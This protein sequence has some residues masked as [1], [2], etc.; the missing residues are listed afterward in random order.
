VTRSAA[1][2]VRG[3]AR[4]SLVSC[5]V[6][7][8]AVVRVALTVAYWPGL[9]YQDSWNYLAC[10]YWLLIRPLALVADRMG[11]MVVAQHLAGLTLGGMV[12][13]LALRLSAPRVHALGAPRLYCSTST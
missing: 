1:A 3:L 12:Y 10:G 8:G 7:L 11:P 4:T 13:W 2:G 6:L 5:A 9:V